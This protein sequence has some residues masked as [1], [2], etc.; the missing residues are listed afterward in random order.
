MSDRVW[1]I[2]LAVDRGALRGFIEG[3]SL[4]T[5][6]KPPLTSTWCLVKAH[7]REQA[8]ELALETYDGDLAPS[9]SLTVVSA[10]RLNGVKVA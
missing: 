9:E 8:I 7:T 5:T 1:F 4:L 2:V 3:T 6:Y 10:A